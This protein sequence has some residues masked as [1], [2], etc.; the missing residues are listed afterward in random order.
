MSRRPRSKDSLMRRKL[1]KS[2]EWQM[3]RRPRN[4]ESPMKKLLLLKNKG[5]L[6]RPPQKSSELQTK[7]LLLRNKDSPKKKN[8]DSPR[9]PPMKKKDGKYRNK[10]KLNMVEKMAD[11]DT[12][13]FKK[14]VNEHIF[15]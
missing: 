1:K 8:R 3:N 11:F 2:N 7:K 9:R 4:R 6:R 5:L 12:H 10:R 14:T 13:T 15:I